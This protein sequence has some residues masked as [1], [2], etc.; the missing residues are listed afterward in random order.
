MCRPWLWLQ[1]RR[2]RL[3]EDK[4]VGA[5]VSVV[6]EGKMGMELLVVG[7]RELRVVSEGKM[8]FRGGEVVVELLGLW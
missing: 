4:L 8:V 1:R 6:L 5:V 2:L 3:P 7:G